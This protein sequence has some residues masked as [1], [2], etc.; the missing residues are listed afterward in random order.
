V[1][2]VPVEMAPAIV[3]TS[4]SPRFGIARPRC[5]SVSFSSCSRVPASTVTNPEPTSARTTPDRPSGAIW[6]PSVTPIAVNECPDPI[7]LTR[8]P[9]ALATTS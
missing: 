9:F 2:C 4:M 5:H 6:M 3:W 7:A 1:P 8:R